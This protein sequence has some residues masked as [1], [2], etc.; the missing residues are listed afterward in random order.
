ML[1]ALD[2]DLA[3]DSADAL[4]DYFATAKCNLIPIYFL[5]L[6]RSEIQSFLH[7]I[8]VVSFQPQ[9]KMRLTFF[10]WNIL[11]CFFTVRCWSW[12]FSIDF[13]IE[14]CKPKPQLESDD[15]GFSILICTSARTPGA[16]QQLKATV[17]LPTVATAQFLP[18]CLS[19]TGGS[20]SGV[21]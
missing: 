15:S 16:G 18:V 13:S 14:T 9:R 20:L 3:I 11:N 2:N 7:E 19:H 8:S 6:C 21:P 12:G 10:S 1:C 17:H 4:L 5:F